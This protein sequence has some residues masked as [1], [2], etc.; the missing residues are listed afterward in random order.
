MVG[1]DDADVGVDVELPKTLIAG[2]Y[3]DIPIRIVNKGG[4]SALVDV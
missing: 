4:K 1:S 3:I 2:D